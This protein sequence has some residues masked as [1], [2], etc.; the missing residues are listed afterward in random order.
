M[1]NCAL[2]RLAYKAGLTR[3][4]SDAYDETRVIAQ[5]YISDIINLAVIYME[6]ENRVTIFPDD[7]VHAIERAG[8]ANVYGSVVGRVK[9]CKVSE[10]VTMIARLREYQAQSDCFTMSKAPLEKLFKETL[11]KIVEETRNNNNLWTRGAGLQKPWKSKWAT[12]QTLKW[13]KDAITTMHT[14][15]EY[16]IYSIFFASLKSMIHGKR[17]TLMKE[18]ISFTMDMIKGTC[19]TVKF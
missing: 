18:D 19:N 13:A 2:Q 12:G 17:V 1:N 11:L 14:A 10:K 9:Q 8:Y 4:S 6:N 5:K 15:V 16:F 3:V 7:I